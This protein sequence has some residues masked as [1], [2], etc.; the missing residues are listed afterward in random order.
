M[1][2]IMISF[3]IHILKA[4]LPIILSIED[5]ENMGIFLDNLSNL[6]QNYRLGRSIPVIGKV[7]HPFGTW[8]PFQEF[9]FSKLQIR[10]LQRRFGHPST[11]KVFNRLRRSSTQEKYEGTRKKLSEI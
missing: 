7:G 9:F 5:M 2:G 4:D 6:L 8:N 3:D 11:E 1:E 10:R